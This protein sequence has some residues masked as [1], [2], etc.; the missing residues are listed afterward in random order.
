[1]RIITSKRDIAWNYVGTIIS[2][3]G[4]FLVLPFFLIFLTETELGLWYVYLAIGNLIMLFDF[5]FNPTFSRNFA[6]CWGGAKELTK[7]GCVKSSSSDP[8]PNLLACLLA[9][10]KVVYA[11]ISLIAFVAL[12]TIGT[13]YILYVSKDLDIVQVLISWAIFSPGVLFNLYYLYYAAMLRGTGN[14][15]A[16]NQ[17]KILARVVQLIIT[18]G[19]LFCGFGLIA[20]SLG[21]FSNAIV[22]RIL[23]YH[24][25]WNNTTIKAMKIKEIAVSK[26]EIDN[27][28]SIISYNAFKDCGVQIANYFSTQA[29]SLIS[30]A[31]LGLDESGKYSLA[32][33]FANAIGTIALAYTNTC[34]PMFQSFF[35]QNK[36]EEIKNRLG[37]CIIV[38]VGLFFAGTFLVILI[39]YPFFTLL[40][41]TSTFSVPIFLG[42]SIYMLFFNWCTLFS[43][44]LSNM[45]YIPYTKAY[46]I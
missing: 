14:I 20:G 29:S 45:N 18:V 6:F 12:A 15:T 24:K 38:Y 21:F 42:V 37:R 39:V 31:Y 35:Q 5:G 1:M 8:N 36:I 34:R 33:Q 26:Q 16:D 30:S 2:L 32:L 10:C 44:M 3:T 27:M 41:P 46:I 25:F 17:I 40:N 28:Y 7:Q 11:K 43:T 13:I 19:L 22:Y 4:N 23:G 9:A